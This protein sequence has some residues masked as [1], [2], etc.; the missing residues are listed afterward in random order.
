MIQTT[1]LDPPLPFTPLDQS[2]RNLPFPSPNQTSTQSQNTQHAP[3]PTSPAAAHRRV[4]PQRLGG[5]AHRLRDRRSRRPCRASRGAGARPVAVREGT[6]CSAT[7][8]PGASERARRPGD[9]RLRAVASPHRDITSHH[10][11]NDAS[12]RDW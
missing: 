8:D 1:H 6:D 3:R 10:S 9:E 11:S 5:V 12:Q 2:K 7:V 4:K